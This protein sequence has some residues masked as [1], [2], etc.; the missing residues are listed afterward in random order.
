MDALGQ[1]ESSPT[2]DIR[3]PHLR[4]LL[5]RF[6]ADLSDPDLFERMTLHGEAIDLWLLHGANEFL[7]DERW[8][9]VDDARY[10]VGI[11]PFDETEAAAA[12]PVMFALDNLLWEGCEASDEARMRSPAWPEVV[13]AATSAL[14]V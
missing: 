5:I 14:R 4:Q 2:S 11:C 3:D 12:Q 6:L 9:F 8:A 7:L 13:S 1:P 10:G